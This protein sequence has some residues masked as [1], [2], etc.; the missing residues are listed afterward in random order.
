I[1]GRAVEIAASFRSNRGV[2]DIYF[3][4]PAANRDFTLQLAAYRIL[5]RSGSYTGAAGMALEARAADGS[6][7]RVISAASI[8]TQTATTGA[9]GNIALSSNLALG[10]GEHLVVHFALDGAA[11]GDLDVRPVFEVLLAANATSTATPTA[12]TTITATASPTATATAT[13][14]A[15]KQL[16]P[17]IRR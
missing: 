9:W 8:D 17:V 11:G 15:P 2:G 14:A 5:S 1:A 4:F 12:T 16:L 13:Q 10:R 7:K 3:I 6:L